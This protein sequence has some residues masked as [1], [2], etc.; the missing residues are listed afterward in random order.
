M[1]ASVSVHKSIALFVQVH[2]IV[3]DTWRNEA[4][5]S[6]VS[7]FW[8]NDTGRFCFSTSER[9]LIESCHYIIIIKITVM[10]NLQKKYCLNVWWWQQPSIF[11]TSLLQWN[12]AL[13]L[14]HGWLQSIPCHPRLFHLSLE[15]YHNWQCCP[16]SVSRY[17]VVHTNTCTVHIQVRHVNPLVGIMCY[18]LYQKMS[19]LRVYVIKSVR[20]QV[21]YMH[22]VILYNVSRL[23]RDT[24][25]LF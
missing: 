20:C 2:N 22:V 9:R 3:W 1:L 7:L 12:L 14:H 6:R 10:T 16:D 23:S 11:P 21:K 13:S 19:R 5:M 4:A 8:T 24:C 18:A 17:S 25:S 15:W